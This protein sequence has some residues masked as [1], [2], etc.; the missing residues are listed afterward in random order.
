[1]KK[2]LWRRILDVLE[3]RDDA[4]TVSELAR[5]VDAPLDAVA[6][7]VK[8]L[9]VLDREVAVLLDVEDW[10]M[11]NP[12]PHPAKFNDQIV[13]AIAAVLTARGLM[14][15][16][17]L[18]LLDP[19]AGTGRVGE[20]QKHGYEGR[21]FLNEIEHEWA[22]QGMKYNPA[23]IVVGDARALPWRNPFFDLVV[24]SP[25]YG[26]R[27][28]D[29]H[30]PSEEDTSDRITYRHKLGRPLSPGSAGGLQWGSAYK[31][32][33]VQ[34]WQEAHRVLKPGG[35][36]VANVKDHYRGDVLQHVADWHA[37]RL[38]WIFGGVIERRKVSSPGMRKGANGKKRVEHEELL[39]VQK[40]A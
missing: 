33:H 8:N 3:E 17:E 18:T 35:L 1:M 30:T 32:L 15:R 31:D 26:N 11:D 6:N 36:L 40:A 28:A 7:T 39:I 16:S 27:M 22:G 25:C 29:C 10:Q 14:H 12:A 21:V 5:L 19:F 9:C 13:G 23:C 38:V 20:L 24:T 2:W 4:I 37:E 34:A